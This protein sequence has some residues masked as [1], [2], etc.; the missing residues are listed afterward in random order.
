MEISVTMSQLNTLEQLIKHSIYMDEFSEL[1]DFADVQ[2]MR[3]N[4]D[5]AALLEH[6]S[7]HLAPC[8][9]EVAA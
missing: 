1:P 4:L 9:S 3:F 6:V 7:E 8:V 5:R 2:E